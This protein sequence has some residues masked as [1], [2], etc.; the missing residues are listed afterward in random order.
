M[1]NRLL[2]SQLLIGV[3]LVLLGASLRDAG[4]AVDNLSGDVGV[5]DEAGAGSERAYDYDIGSALLA[6]NRKQRGE[7]SQ[8]TERTNVKSSWRDDL[9]KTIA[10]P[11]AEDAAA[12]YPQ[13]GLRS[14]GA[15]VGGLVEGSFEGAKQGE[16]NRL[17][18]SAEGYRH[19]VP[20]W[21]SISHATVR[22]VIKE[23]AR[24]GRVP[25]LR[26]V[27]TDRTPLERESALYR[28]QTP[29]QDAIAS[30]ATA[31]TSEVEASKLL[32]GADLE[33]S[34]D[35]SLNLSPN[36]SFLECSAAEL[37][38][39]LAPGKFGFSPA[40]DPVTGRCRIQ[41]FDSI[42]NWRSSYG[43][44]LFAESCARAQPFVDF[45][46]G[47]LR[48]DTTT[49]LNVKRDQIDKLLSEHRASLGV[50]DPVAIDDI[51]L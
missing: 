28:K 12:L 23:A 50:R 22:G 44:L 39:S 29:L 10:R 31:A 40:Y 25:I 9:P 49:V 36:F 34:K 30:N 33:L 26:S 51:D 3:H 6:G 13:T 17:S 37:L 35:G 42:S 7:R 15:G 24:R 14:D 2:G 5:E 4:P 18:P 11:T 47:V 8:R 48:N 41:P 16:G 32:G 27:L 1:K 45:L 19:R 46:E 38:C 21:A 20:T 43:R